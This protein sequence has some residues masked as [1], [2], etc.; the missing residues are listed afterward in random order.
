[1]IQQQINQLRQSMRK[2]EM[3]NQVLKEERNTFVQKIGKLE[4]SAKSQEK[5]I[6]Y[7]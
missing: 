3:E 5:M 7:L 6:T 1:M 2:F 4:Q